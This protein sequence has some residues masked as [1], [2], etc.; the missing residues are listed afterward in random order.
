MT[1][2]DRGEDGGTEQG[3][4]ADGEGRMRPLVNACRAI[5]TGSRPDWPGS[6]AAAAS[7]PPRVSRAAAAAQGRIPEGRAP[8][9]WLR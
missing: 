5:R 1:E 8:F 9:S 2:L 3:G 4:G 6:C 7:A